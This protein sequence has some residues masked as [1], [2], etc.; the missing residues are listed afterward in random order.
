MRAGR[1][2]ELLRDLVLGC[3]VVSLEEDAVDDDVARLLDGAGEAVVVAVELLGRNE[4]R[5]PREGRAE[6]RERR[7]EC[8]EEGGD[9]ADGSGQ[10]VWPCRALARSL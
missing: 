4:L 1:T 3:D 5:E 7:V 9:C 2:A 6:R 8:S 10:S